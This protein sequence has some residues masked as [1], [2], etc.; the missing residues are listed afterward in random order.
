MTVFKIQNK[1]CMSQLSLSVFLFNT[2]MVH[3]DFLLQIV[4]NYSLR[5]PT[6]TKNQNI[7]LFLRESNISKVIVSHD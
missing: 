3:A 5:H 2:D 1:R 4:M 6:R 7:F